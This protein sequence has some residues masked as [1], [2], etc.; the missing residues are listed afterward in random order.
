MAEVATQF[1]YAD[2]SHLTG[3]FTKIIGMPPKRWLGSLLSEH[4]VGG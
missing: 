3:D 1:G 4:P 2:Q